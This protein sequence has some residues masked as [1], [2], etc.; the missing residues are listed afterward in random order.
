MSKILRTFLLTT[1]LLLALADARAQATNLLVSQVPVAPGSNGS[2]FSTQ[3]KVTLRDGA[4]ATVTTDSTTVVTM[5]VSRNATVVGTATATCAS[6]VATFSGVGIAGLTGATYTL[7]FT[8]TGASG[9]LSVDQNIVNS[10]AAGPASQLVITAIPS[11]AVNGAA[12]G[13]DLNPT[14]NY[15]KVAKWI[16]DLPG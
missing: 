15:L 2:A 11:F 12:F 1:A 13:F 7:T 8:S 5:T 10:A 16:Y 6:G 4:N 9:G 3:P 14:P